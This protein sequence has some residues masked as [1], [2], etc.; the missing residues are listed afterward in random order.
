MLILMIYL[1]YSRAKRI[2]TDGTISR[3]AKQMQGHSIDLA[4]GEIDYERQKAKRRHKVYREWAND[5][6]KDMIDSL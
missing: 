1:K 4:Y 5:Q 6:I 2:D 3:I